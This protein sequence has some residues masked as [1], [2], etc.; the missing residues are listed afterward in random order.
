M[1]KTAARWRQG[2]QLRANIFL[3]ESFQHYP[4]MFEKVIGCD[5]GIATS[6][7]PDSLSSE[8]EL[9]FIILPL[10]ILPCLLPELEPAPAAAEL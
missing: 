3:G 6:T 2:G 1:V 9:V 4:K 5:C 10:M 8:L 7:V